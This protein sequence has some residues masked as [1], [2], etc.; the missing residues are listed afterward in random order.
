MASEV[1]EHEPNEIVSVR[2]IGGQLDRAVQRS[3]R[4]IVQPSVVQH[5]S[6][7]LMHER[8]LVVELE[9]ALEPALRLFEVA[10]R[11]FREAE[12]DDRANVVWSVLQNRV[13]FR[14]CVLPV[15]DGGVRTAELPARV[16]IIRLRAQAIAKLGDPAVVEARV[17]VR[18]LEIALRHL[19]FRVELESARERGDGIL[20]HPLV[21]IQDA[22]I[23]V[24]AGIRAV[25]APSERPQNVAIALGDGGG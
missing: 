12:L 8:A 1:A 25:D 7:V 20:V 15:A 9:R 21:V 19:H 13:E 3:E 24:R 14:D 23:V 6:D 10:V 18:H 22:E 5:L 16:A 2:I 4:L 11:L 17:K